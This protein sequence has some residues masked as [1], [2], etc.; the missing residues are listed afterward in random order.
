MY[1]NSYD[2]PIARLVARQILSCAPATPVREAARRMFAERCSSIVVMKEEQVVGIWTEHDALSAG[3]NPGELDRPVSEV[4]SHPVLTLE[5]DTPLGEAAMK[6]KQSGVRHFVVVRDG[7]AIGVLTQTDVV[8]NQG[9]EFFLHLKPIESIRVHP[10]V[11]VPEQ[12]G[13][14][15]VIA[16]MRAQRLDA[17]LVGYDDGEHGILTERDIVRLL[18][19]GGAQGAV[20][21]HASKPLQMLTARQSLYAA[22]RFMTEHNMR[23]VGIR[24]DDGRLTGLLCFADVLQ[25]IEHEY[26]NELRSALRERDEAL[27]LAR[28]NLRMADRVFES[29]LEG[30]MVTDRRA[31][32]ER[33]N[34]AF[35]R[36]T[37]YSEDE[38]IGRDPGLLSSGRQTPDFYKQLW[39]SLTTD[40]H[41]QGEIWNRRKT[42]EL[43]LE[44]LTITSIRDSNGEISHYAA[45]FSDIT[46]RRQAEERLGY[47]A[48]HD[49]L[50]N[51]ANRMLFEER[52]AHAISHAKRFGRKVA[53]M[54]LDLDR[55]KLINDTLGHNAGDEVLKMVAER[56]VA[57]VR[58]NDTVARMG[59]DEFALVLEEIDDVRDVGRVA[60]KLLDEVGR[61]IDI[62]DR[63]IFVTPSIGISIYPDDGTAAEDLILLADQAMY[64]AKSRGRNV[65]QFFESKMTSSAIEQLETLGELHRALE[66]NEF[67]LFY[68]PQYD[69]ASGRIVGVEALLRWLHP[70]RGLVPPGDFIGLAERSALIVPIGKWVLHEA[71]RQARRWLDEGFEFGRV[72]VNVSARQCFTD[73][74]LSDLTT[75]LSETALPAEYLQLELLES[76]AM[77]TREEIGILLRELATR[78]ISLA[79]DDF[80]TGYSSLVYLKDLPV[81]TLKI[82][83]SFLAD[84]GSGS[85]DDAIVRAIVAM[86]RALGL[87]VVM[88][89]VE[90]AKQLAFLQEI[91]CHQGQGF[92]FARPQPAEQLVGISSRRGAELLTE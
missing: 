62:G 10:P 51:L 76:M 59:G 12:A 69:L 3:D 55:F 33:V 26:A 75:I 11:V 78:G 74:F 32:I 25:S 9:P 48:T 53:V 83:R 41:W 22:Q 37:G 90:T 61:A 35:T 27:G 24:D 20:G 43:F 30:I 47:L 64:G 45:I 77:N 19:D 21:A 5:A 36:L 92:L 44:Y 88:E 67:R 34:Q 81:D 70:H 4:M 85:T 91:G 50:T 68:Q 46:Q 71:C 1:P 84:C 42:G 86:G 13:L 29:A 31:R 15:D 63:E 38:V 89:G 58:A 80:G 40:G 60:R 66:Q 65:F 54:Y 87:D 73:H 56:I 2:V 18:A 28:F 7:A 49:V 82:D 17:I 14:H 79:I 8:V 6:F 39:H 72:S 16:Q 23:H 57:N 52:L